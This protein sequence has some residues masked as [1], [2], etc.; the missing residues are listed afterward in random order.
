MK[1]N[2][3]TNLIV[4]VCIFSICG[5]RVA[6]TPQGGT[7]TRFLLDGDEIAEE[8][9]GS[10]TTSFVGGTTCLIS[11]ISGSDRQI[12]HADG[13][14]SSRA[15]TGADEAVDGST[16]YDAFGSQAFAIQGNPQFGYAGQ[17]RYYTDQSGMMYLKARYYNPGTGRFVSRDSFGFIDGPNLYNY[18]HGNPV[19]R[20]DPDGHFAWVPIIGVVIIGVGVEQGIEWGVDMYMCNRAL[21]E[22]MD[23]ARYYRDLFPDDSAK[24]LEYIRQT[25]AWENMLEY[26]S[27]CAMTS[28]SDPVYPVRAW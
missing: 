6:Q 4:L 14:G 27:S 2:V 26:C 25:A 11:Q 7:T 13:L 18:A 19:W 5:M 16:V 23:W 9:S 21:G 12:I 3:L 20:V 15:M 28:Y 17:Y 22:L 1:T 10:S 24:R 8:I